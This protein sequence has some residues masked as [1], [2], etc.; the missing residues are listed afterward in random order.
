M[1]VQL[2]G[3]EDNN[4]SS[5]KNAPAN[6]AFASISKNRFFLVFTFICAVLS[7]SEPV[8]IAFPKESIFIQIIVLGTSTG[9]F[10]FGL[11]LLFMAMP[12]GISF[13]Q[14]IRETIVP[15]AYIEVF[16]FVL[17]WSTFFTYP[18]LSCLRCFRIFRYLWYL[19]FYFNGKNTG[20]F[21]IP[22]YFLPIVSYLRK[23]GQDFFTGASK[24][25]IV[26]IGLYF[27]LIF[28]IA[29]TVWQLSNRGS[30]DSDFPF[31]TTPPNE[32]CHSL[33]HCYLIMMRLSV[34]E[35][36]GLDFLKAVMDA[37]FIALSVLLMMFMCC[38]GLIL[39]NGLIGIFGQAF[40]VP[41]SSGF[42]IV[43]TSSRQDESS[44]RQPD[45]QWPND[46]EV[47]L[48]QE[49]LAQSVS[50]IGK[51]CDALMK[52][53]SA[54]KEMDRQSKAWQNTTPKKKKF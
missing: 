8:L 16:S 19:E 20:L 31:E 35:G 24:G 12:S 53:V 52:E 1:N 3:N 25:G 37:G 13:S 32:M 11:I 9:F 15:E 18:P 7:L 46:I 38:S 41:R 28:L 45:A 43:Q 17:G 47:L 51:L 50:R 30:L 44:S 34:F 26:I 49:T 39:L 6:V 48:N 5:T 2:K 22:Q 54:I 36:L 14:K 23:I 10:C 4:V 27:Y 40:Q 33:P 21:Y 29:V 42:S